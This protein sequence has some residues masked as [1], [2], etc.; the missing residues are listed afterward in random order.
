MLIMLAGL[1]AYGLPDYERFLQKAR[2]G[3]PIT[4][5]YL[6][7]SI[8]VGGS[9]SPAQGV[10]RVG[11]KYRY[12]MDINRDSWRALTFEWLRETYE[13]K[14]GQFVQVSAGLGATGSMMGSYR[15]ARDILSYKPDLLF[16]EY[17]INDGGVGKITKE[18][19]F[20]RRS[21]LRTYQSIISR[22][23]KQNPDCAIF[24]PISTYRDALTR[25]HELFRASAEMTERAAH[26]FKVPFADIT[27]VCYKDP[28][29][30][31]LERDRLFDGP[32]SAGNRVHP[33]MQGHRAYAEGV[34]AVLKKAFANEPFNF[35]KQP[36]ENVEPSPRFPRFI[37]A[38]E[39]MPHATGDWNLEEYTERWERE[40]CLVG[41]PSLVTTDPDAALELVLKG[42]SIGAWL[43]SGAVEVFLDG[44][45]LGIYRKS[46]KGK[47]K[48]KGRFRLFSNALDPDMEHRLKLIP[49][50]SEKIVLHGLFVDELQDTGADE[51]EQ[52]TIDM[53][54]LEVKVE[55]EIDDGF[56][57]PRE[58]D[59]SSVLVWDF[60]T[61]EGWETQ[62]TCKKSLADGILHIE[63]IGSKTAD[64][65]RIIH[66][67]I[68][69][70][71][72]PYTVNIRLRSV[73]GTATG[74]RGVAFWTTPSSPK[75]A[76]GNRKDF[77]VV[78]DGKWHD[79]ELVIP[80]AEPLTS[81]VLYTRFLPGI[82]EIDRV[83]LKGRS[84]SE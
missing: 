35:K 6:G 63:M 64:R 79:Y 28:L 60:D 71:G 57:I 13:Q 58:K 9:T 14:P 20:D 52:R 40:P 75:V 24:I 42:T 67:D 76:N 54:L 15:L 41:Y 44:K 48:F 77:A 51:V 68:L 12:D 73:G 78:N 22:V 5:A 2:A 46:G 62:S 39:L 56:T 72:G 29:P 74:E 59:A 47:S 17:A 50:D 7:G 27:R 81:L 1:A 65:A 25:E 32:E 69:T 66:K 18:N 61:L 33:S 43:Q 10:D 4:V 84:K 80:V 36:F 26:W 19:P 37:P 34:I 31:G 38:R 82:S 8:T 70:L 3:E 23:K 49:V 30:E 16:I 53:S 83:E 55:Q 21:I 45:A 11:R